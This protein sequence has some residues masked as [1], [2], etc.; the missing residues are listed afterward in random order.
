MMPIGEAAKLPKNPK[1]L[2]KAAN[3]IVN[4]MKIT[5]KILTGRATRDSSPI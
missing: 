3:S 4:G 5:I 2:V 1:K